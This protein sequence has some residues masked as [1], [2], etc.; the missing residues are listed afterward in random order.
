ML[1]VATHLPSSSM[2]G[3]ADSLSRSSIRITSTAGIESETVCTG[4]LIR[5]RASASE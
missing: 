5:S 1:K 4:R 2:T 3:I